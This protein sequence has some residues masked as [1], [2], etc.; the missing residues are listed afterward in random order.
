M[1]YIQQLIPVSAQE[2]FILLAVFI[3]LV[4]FIGSG[5]RYLVLEYEW[6]KLYKENSEKM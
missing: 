3:V 1:D 4:I 2:F 6:R 5:I